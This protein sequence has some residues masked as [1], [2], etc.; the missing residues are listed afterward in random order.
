MDIMYSPVKNKIN[1][2]SRLGINKKKIKI[3]GI[4]YIDH[5]KIKPLKP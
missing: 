1:T 4:R 3:I 2:M 5:N